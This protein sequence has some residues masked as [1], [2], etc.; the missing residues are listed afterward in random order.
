MDLDTGAKITWCPGCTN[1]LI[2][3]AFKEVVEELV[4]EGYKKERFVF[5]TGIGCHGKLHDYINLNSFYGLHGRVIATMQG[6]KIA[7]PDLITVAFM[8]DGDA[9]AEGLDHL[10]FAAKRNIDAK[11]FVHNNGVFAL[12]TGQFTPTTP[13]GMKTKT[14][15]KGNPERPINPILL[16]LSAGASFVARVFVGEYDHMKY[17]M[18]EAIKHKGFA[19]VDILQPCITFNNTFQFY[20]ERVYK[21]E[22]SGHDPKNFE[23][24]I[25]KALEWDYNREDVKIPIGIFYKK[26]MEVFKI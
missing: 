19:F 22:D 3:K 21:L 20:K 2:L 13:K 23:Q 4:K 9:Y 6:V 10:I 24:A 15:P 25:K 11:A 16:M 12:T 8:G 26:E 18:K 7:N 5:G 14:T 17:V 1:Y